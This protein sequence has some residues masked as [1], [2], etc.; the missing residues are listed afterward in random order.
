MKYQTIF[1]LSGIN[2]GVSPLLAAEGEL[3]DT[4]N[5]VSEKIGVL[6]K[7]FD[8][9]IKNAQIH[10]SQN[11]VGGIDYARV[12]GTHTHLVACDSI[13]G[14]DIYENV[15]GTWTA[16]SQSLTTGT[17]VRFAVDPAL[18]TLFAANYSDATRSYNGSAWSISTNVTSAPKFKYIFYFGNRVWG[19]FANTGTAYPTRGYRSSLDDAGSITWDTTNDWFNFGDVLT[20][21]GK[22]GDNMFVGCENSMFIVPLDADA[23]YRVSDHGCVSHESIAS[24]GVWTFWAA[25]D[26]VYAF[27]GK[28]DKKISLSIQDYWDGI[29]EANL[30][31][32]QAVVLGHHLYIYVGA[33]TSPDTYSNVIF[34]YNILQNT[35]NRG[36]LGET[37]TNLHTYITS[38][39]KKVFMGN[40]EGEVFQL[41]NSST[42]FTKAFPASLETNWLY[43]SGERYMDTFYELW[44][45]GDQLSGIQVFYKVDNDTDWNAIGDLNGPTDFVKFKVKAYRIKYRIHEYSKNNLYSLHGL[46]HGFEPQY[47]KEKD[48]EK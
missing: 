8:F 9:S 11:I 40:D 46:E 17:K 1:G 20:G 28:E 43:G 27:N 24:Y 21:V 38:S 7:S 41:F 4:E 22:N 30:S 16:A 12:S 39:G 29:A 3:L 33:L 45:Y 6:K 13:S 5:L 42:Q 2:R 25:R 15:A 10:A 36:F 32:I 14:V 31:S 19:F 18:D 35:W 48:T 37:M 26:G 47:P 44:G 34:D 23:M